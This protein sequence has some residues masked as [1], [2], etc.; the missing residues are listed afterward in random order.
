MVIAKSARHLSAIVFLAGLLSA[1]VAQEA[2][3]VCD[4]GSAN[5]ATGGKPK[6][7]CCAAQ[8]GS[9][10]PGEASLRRSVCRSRQEMLRGRVSAVPYRRDAGN[11]LGEWSTRSRPSHIGTGEAKT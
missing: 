3:K 8:S 2:P 9:A 7:C 5:A 10:Q 6:E 4:Q 11:P 1:A